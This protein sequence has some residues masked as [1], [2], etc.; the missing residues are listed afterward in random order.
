VRKQA[1]LRDEYRCQRCLRDATDVH[2]RRVKG[3][4][5]TSDEEINFG[6]A[7][8]ISV[9]RECHSYIH[10]NP[11]ESYELGWLVHSWEDPEDVLVVQAEVC[12]FLPDRVPAGHENPLGE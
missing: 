9:C 2:H 1:L 7:N 3:M 11:A 8:L 4:G 6:L 5:G 12:E 10:L